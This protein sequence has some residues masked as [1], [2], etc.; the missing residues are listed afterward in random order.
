MCHA[1]GILELKKIGAIAE[2]HRVEMSPHNPQGIVSTLA[3]MHV[4]A[5][6]PAAHDS[7]VLNRRQTGWMLDLFGGVTIP[8]K[9]G[10]AELPTRPGLGAALDEKVA[11]QHPYK[12]VNRPGY[13]FADGSIADY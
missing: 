6:T 13:R 4:N 10:H 9:D 3:S 11:A 5:T 7:G 12:A 8:I 1:G 2:A